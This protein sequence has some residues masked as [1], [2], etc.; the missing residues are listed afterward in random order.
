M[1]F[2]PSALHN[3][4]AIAA[5]VSDEESLSEI[6]DLGNLMLGGFVLAVGLAIALTFIRLKMREKKPP[7]AQFISISSLDKK[8]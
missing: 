8:E 2:L 7:V 4:M 6:G 5:T 1:M 3:L